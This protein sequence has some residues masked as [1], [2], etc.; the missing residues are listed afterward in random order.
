VTQEDRKKILRWTGIFSIPWVVLGVLFWLATRPE[1]P[2]PGTEAVVEGVRIDSGMR[3][4]DDPLAKSS[5]GC[6]ILRYDDG[7]EE[8]FWEAAI[9]AEHVNWDSW[10]PTEDP[11]PRVRVTVAEERGCEGRVYTRLERLPDS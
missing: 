11:N 1:K 9:G 6:L 2:I 4:D 5:R 10:N 3:H 7:T 8:V